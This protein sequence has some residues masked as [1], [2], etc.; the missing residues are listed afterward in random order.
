MGYLNGAPPEGHARQCKTFIKR[1]GRRCRRWALT[2]RDHCKKHAGRPCKAPMSRKQD[3]KGFYS[4]HLGPTLRDAMRAVGDQPTNKQLSLFEELRL[5]RAVA[6]EVMALAQGA[7]SEKGS[8]KSKAMACEIMFD[9]LEKVASLVERVNKIE[10]DSADKLS[11]SAVDDFVDQLMRIMREE[12]GDEHHALIERVEARCKEQIRVP[13]DAMRG[14]G[15]SS[16][17][18]PVRLR[19]AETDAKTEVA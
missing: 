13:L 3:H 5:A 12:A 6:C 4:K 14:G 15:A 8:D 10:Q 16:R 9:A 1:L 19:L 7:F 2:G 18:A 11:L 17:G